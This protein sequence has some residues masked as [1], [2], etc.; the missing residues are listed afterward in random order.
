MSVVTALVPDKHGRGAVRGAAEFLA[1]AETRGWNPGPL[2]VGAV[3]TSQTFISHTSNSM[4]S[5]T[6]P[7]TRCIRPTAGCS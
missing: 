3:F 5:A 2:P 1:W 6:G 4:A 7:P